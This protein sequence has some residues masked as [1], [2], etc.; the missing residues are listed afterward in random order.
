MTPL[1]FARTECADYD[2]GGC[3]GAA[4]DNSSCHPLSEC[5]LHAGERCA[6]FENYVLPMADRGHAAFI[7]ARG[8]YRGFHAM[9]ASGDAAPAC[10]ACGQPRAPRKSLCESCARQHRRQTTRNG[11]RKKRSSC[12]QS[13]SQTGL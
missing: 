6:Y 8:Q 13:S 9:K 11:M 1:E 12:E 3:L 7:E 5:R 4:I 2:Q 10:S